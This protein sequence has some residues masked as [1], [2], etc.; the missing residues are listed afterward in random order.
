MRPFSIV[1]P[2]CQKLEPEFQTEDFE[3][4]SQL[5]ELDHSV[6]WVAAICPW[7]IHGLQ[8]YFQFRCNAALA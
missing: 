3:N 1:P 5:L 8:S 2:A 6:L 7:K 4:E